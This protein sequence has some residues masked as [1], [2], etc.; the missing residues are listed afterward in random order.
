MQSP[1]AIWEA[2]T[3]GREEGEWDG[4]IDGDGD[5]DV[6]VPGEHLPAGST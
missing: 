6:E 5:R 2:Y 4:C 3:R 1:T